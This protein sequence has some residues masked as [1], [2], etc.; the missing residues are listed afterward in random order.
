MNGPN[1]VVDFFKSNVLVDERRA[2]KDLRV[3]Q[4]HAPIGA[5]VP[6]F[7]VTGIFQRG[8]SGRPGA[9]GRAVMP[10]RHL[11]AESL[12]RAFFVVFAPKRV[13]AALLAAERVGRG[14]GRLR[15]QDAM[16][17]LVRS[18]L[19]G[20]ARNDLFDRNPQPEPGHS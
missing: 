3:A 19:I 2:D 8:R 5:D 6:G 17:L 14:T 13:K 11:I 16:K 10:R 12:M 4:P 18:I 15:F 1:A 9:W 7:P 20:T